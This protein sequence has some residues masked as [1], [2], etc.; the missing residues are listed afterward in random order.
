MV[1]IAQELEAVSTLVTEMV[2][3]AEEV[4]MVPEAAGGVEVS[5]D[6]DEALEVDGNQVMIRRSL[7]WGM[8][9]G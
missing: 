9:F 5:E 6:G 1:R 8:V 4:A 2:D 7:S 3:M